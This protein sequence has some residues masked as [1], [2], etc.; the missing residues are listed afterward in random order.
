LDEV[1]R[2]GERSLVD[3]EKWKESLL[4]ASLEGNKWEQFCVH[5]EG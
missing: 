1:E 5:G 4:V 2:R 3:H